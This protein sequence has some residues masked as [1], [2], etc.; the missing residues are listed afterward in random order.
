MDST[1]LTAST[2]IVAAEPVLSTTIDGETVILHKGV[3]RYYGL[4]DVGT[5]IWKLLEEPRTVEEICEEVMNEYDVGY[6]RCKNDVEDIVSEMNKKE[7]IQFDE[8]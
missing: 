3:E 2:T 7:L 8:P 1:S 4:N 5:F 6:Q